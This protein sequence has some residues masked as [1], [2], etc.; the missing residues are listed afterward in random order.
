MHS[1]TKEL[2]VFIW[3]VSDMES[4]WAVQ[5]T[6]PSSET[7]ENV[8]V[9]HEQVAPLK[10]IKSN[11]FLLS[12]S[13][14]SGDRFHQQK[15]NLGNFYDLEIVISKKTTN[16]QCFRNYIIFSSIHYYYYDKVDSA[17]VHM[18]PE[19]RGTKRIFGVELSKRFLICYM[20]VR[21]T[22]LISCQPS[23]I[24]KSST[25]GV[26]CL[27][28]PHNNGSPKLDLVTNDAAEDGTFSGFGMLAQDSVRRMLS[29][30]WIIHRE[31]ER[32]EFSLGVF[33]VWFRRNQ[34]R[35]IGCGW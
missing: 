11:G 4:G 7:G 35:S 14:R 32:Y 26:G 34:A 23:L 28:P 29:G 25:L 17:I 22:A 1:P 9:D 15:D 2:L 5:N 12:E 13:S 20:K 3:L 8:N 6:S 19:F 27:A 16:S 31:Q 18:F 21:V 24:Q 10:P 30:L 33:H